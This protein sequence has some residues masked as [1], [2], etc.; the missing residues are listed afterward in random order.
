MQDDV[1]QSSKESSYN[2]KFVKLLTKIPEKK[3][4]IEHLCNLKMCWIAKEW[5]T[6]AMDVPKKCSEDNTAMGDV[7][8]QQIGVIDLATA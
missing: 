2:V 1:G 4:T 5:C 8:G 7:S 3:T 6:A